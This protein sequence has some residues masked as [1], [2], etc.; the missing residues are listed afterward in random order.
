MAIVTE[1]TREGVV[2]GY[3]ARLMGKDRKW[4]RSKSFKTKS[5]ARAFERR[6]YEQRSAESFVKYKGE[7]VSVSQYWDQW[8]CES[9]GKVS[10][11]WKLSQD[12]MWEN[13]IKPVLGNFMM[14]EVRAID[15]GAC[16]NR[17][18][19][20]LG[21]QSR[22]HL[23]SLLRRMFSEA[24][25]YSEIIPSSPI[26]PKF[27]RPEV[28]L[29]ERSFLR[30]EETERLLKGCA[31]P[32]EEAIW[33]QLLA[34]LRSSEVQG[35]RW[36]AV[37]FD[38]SRIV[39]KEAYNVKMRRFQDFPKQGDWGSAPL[40]HVLAEYLKPKRRGP[41]K[42][43]LSGRWEDEPFSYGA[44]QR[45][46]RDLCK[47]LGLPKVTPH[48]LRHS[49]TELYFQAGA[50]TEDVRRLLNHASLSAT[51]RY[52]HRTDERLNRI[53]EGVSEA[54]FRDVSISATGEKKSGQEVPTVE[55]ES[56]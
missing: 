27:H 54:L 31:G 30:P 36:G 25:E 13:Y 49:A 29:K 51:K 35:L 4:L 55:R 3:R 21:P 19:D 17:S 10:D 28:P 24:V 7:I 42:L 39:I 52:I 33:L 47:T 2:T 48:E 56:A 15:I 6:L 40:P 9:R 44:Y 12:K 8:S 23:Y 5:E 45:G 50:S 53:A 34:G 32:Y 37:E 22:K 20:R 18:A 14:T 1:K 46:L 11:G 41:Q 26:K 38:R 43:V 16:L